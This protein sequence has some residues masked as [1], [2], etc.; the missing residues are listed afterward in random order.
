MKPG[1]VFKWYFLHF[2][3]CYKINEGNNSMNIF[4]SQIIIYKKIT[5]DADDDVSPVFTFD[6]Q[7]NLLFHWFSAP[8]HQTNICHV[9]YRQQLAS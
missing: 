6:N 8:C 2:P 1:N 7:E 3:Y 5:E 4:K 9:A